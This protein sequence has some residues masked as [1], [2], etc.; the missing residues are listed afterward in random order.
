[1]KKS[2]GRKRVMMK[3][4]RKAGNPVQNL[5]SGFA[6]RGKIGRAKLCVSDISQNVVIMALKKAMKKET[7]LSI[8]KSQL[9]I[10]KTKIEKCFKAKGTT[11]ASEIPKLS[12]KLSIFF[13][14]RG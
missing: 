6:I 14:P 8:V 7:Y 10:Y 1:M 9:E 5:W 2:T 4:D 13:S 3:L 12:I 11:K